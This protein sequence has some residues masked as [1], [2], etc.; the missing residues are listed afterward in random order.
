[1]TIDS[2][3]KAELDFTSLEIN[4]QQCEK[5]EK[6]KE[7]KEEITEADKEEEYI[8]N[9][10]IRKSQFNYNRSTC[11]G[12]NHPEIHVAENTSESTQVAPSQG[13]IP[14]KLLHE[15][16]VDV[17]T[18]PCLFPDGKNGKDQ[19]RKVA[20]KDQDYWCQR[21]LNVDDR[22]SNCPAFTFMAAAHTQANE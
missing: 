18:F 14:N 4:S 8:Q 10:V 17:K 22:F 1:M 5:K 19:E 9:D 15:K 13:K 11:F 3:I 21:I 12:E 6:V 2:Q 16:D 7:E 20:L